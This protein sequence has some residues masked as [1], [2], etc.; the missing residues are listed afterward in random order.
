MPEPL[1]CFAAAAAAR[2]MLL[3]RNHLIA[4]GD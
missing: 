1:T 2:P 4:L 3:L